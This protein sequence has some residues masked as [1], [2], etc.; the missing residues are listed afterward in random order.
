MLY[1]HRPVD[2]VLAHHCRKLSFG[3]GP[4]LL[5]L[6]VMAGCWLNLAAC[7]SP[8]PSLSPVILAL[9][10][11]PPLAIARASLI[12]P[13][14]SSSRLAAASRIG[15]AIQWARRDSSAG[16]AGAARFIPRD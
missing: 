7:R 5:S 15:T 4:S 10:S 9:I 16:Q 14:P 8:A 1:S 3:P 12:R 13:F 6:V 2:P 11:G